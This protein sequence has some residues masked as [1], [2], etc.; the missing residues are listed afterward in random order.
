[1]VNKIINYETTTYGKTWF[2]KIVA[3]GGDSHDDGGTKYLEGE[4]TCD[5]ALSYIP[6]FTP[7]KLYASNKDSDPDH[8]PLKTNIKREISAGCGF[9]FFEGHAS[10]Y[11]WSTHWPGEFDGMMEGGGISVYDFPTLNNGDKLPICVVVGCHNSQFNV[12]FLATLL[13][14]P[15]LWTYG[16]PIP[17]CWSWWLARKSGGGA[18]ATIGATGLGYGAVGEHGD[19]NGDGVNE[20]DCVEAVSPYLA[21]LFFKA[22]N[23]GADNLGEAW[24]KSISEYLDTF[25][26]MADQGDAKQV[27]Q[28]P[29]LGDPSLKIGGYSSN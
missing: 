14:M 1:M 19:I 20:P 27:E 11:R 18:I 15:Y 25:P 10:P 8:T 12:S 24:G 5:K 7:V 26:A 29:L 2:N 21:I 28:W 6:D 16:V 4:L 22:Y 13:K 3:I 9:L 17:E 23:E